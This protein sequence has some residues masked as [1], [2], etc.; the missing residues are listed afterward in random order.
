M[1]R[2][3]YDDAV[4]MSVLDMPLCKT[5]QDGFIMGFLKAAELQYSRD[6]HDMRVMCSDLLQEIG[7]AGPD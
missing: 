4:A 3:S 2:L 5:V 7:D 6:R 1:R